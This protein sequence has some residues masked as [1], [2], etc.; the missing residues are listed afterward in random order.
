MGKQATG[1]VEWAEPKPGE[2]Q[3][4]YKARIT[5]PDGTRP[6]IHFD[7]GPRSPQAEARAREKAA[8]ASERARRRGAVLLSKGRGDARTV[9]SG[10]TV[11][12]YSDLWIADRRT[13]GLTSARDDAARIKMHVLPLIGSHAM[14]DVTREDLVQLVEAF[15]AAVRDRKYRWKTAINIFHV[16]TRMFAD[17]CNSKSLELRVLSDNPALGVRGPDRGD[18]RSAQYLYP[19]EAVKLL[20]CDAVPLR[21]RVI[22]A[23]A[24]YTGLRRGELQVLRPEHVHLDGGYVSVTKARDR[25]TLGEKGTKGRRSRRVPIEPSLR[26]LLEFL[27][28]HPR[29]KDG[30]LVDLPC[31]K[32]ASEDL[33]EHLQ[34]AGVVRAELYSDDDQSRQVNFHSLRH[35]YATWLALLGKGAMVVQQRGGWSDLGM[36]MRYVEDAEVVGLGDVGVAFP[37]LPCG[38]VLAVRESVLGIVG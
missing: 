33:R 21:W 2:R 36:V 24:M 34:R 19:S 20:E 1:T 14:E 12:E 27:V 9:S 22:Y 38:F 31:V 18:Q 11:S 17:A 7:P 16:V 23:M 25:V 29:G 13:R 32:G 6:W 28:A 5:L 8:E 10:M 30:E 37:V 35:T 3:G 15:D 26:P 4:H